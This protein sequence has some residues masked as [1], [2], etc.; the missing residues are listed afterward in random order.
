MLKPIELKLLRAKDNKKL[1][2]KASSVWAPNFVICN[3]SSTNC[4]F[5]LAI[6]MKQLA[7]IAQNIFFKRKKLDSCCIFIQVK[8]L[9]TFTRHAYL[10][11]R[12][13][14]PLCVLLKHNKFLCSD[15]NGSEPLNK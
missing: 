12:P 1:V 2:I 7:M 14:G 8:Q 15:D 9:T 13:W 5:K 4:C 3:K 6:P 11:T 10:L